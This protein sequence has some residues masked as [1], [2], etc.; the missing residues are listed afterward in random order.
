[1]SSS[2]F[3]SL[4]TGATLAFLLIYRRIRKKKQ[5]RTT[6]ERSC[7]S[8]SSHVVLQQ[9]PQ[10]NATFSLMTYNLWKTSGEPTAWT[11]R[12]P[13]LLRQLRRLDPDIMFVQELC[14]KIT[15]C[16]I[17]ALT[18]HDHVKDDSL[19]GWSE[20]GNIFWRTELFEELEHGAVDIGQ[21]EELRRLWWVRLVH[22]ATGHKALFATAHFSWQ[23]SPKECISEANI[24]KA[25]SRR[26]AEA[27]AQLQGDCTA[28]F[29]GGDLNESFWP[30]RILTEAGFTD[31]FAALS[32]PV[33]PTH[34]TRPLLIHE[35][36]NA[37]AALD[38][39]FYKGRGV[40]VLLSA[41]INGM[42][43]L[44]SDDPHEKQLLSVQPS[45]HM[46]VVTVFR[47]M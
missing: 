42:S 18:G 29:F 36:R 32:L 12:R 33:R 14:P 19:K 25:Q 28:V 45:D 4:A 41:V 31:C 21:A 16:V 46:P 24:R 13:V 11:E 43:G 5:M 10:V 40:R 23:G 26:T 2:S 20:E 1:M 47:I 39:L 35:E 22:R 8:A 27:L 44:S 37:D 6:Q 30:L 15:S 17:E 7:R 3:A 34:P 9:Q 38:W